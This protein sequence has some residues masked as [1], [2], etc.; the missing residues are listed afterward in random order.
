MKKVGLLMYRVFIGI[1]LF[2]IAVNA[3]E[4][5][6]TAVIKFQATDT[7]HFSFAKIF[8]EGVRKALSED[9]T[10][11]VLE[12]SIVDEMLNGSSA[13]DYQN[14]KNENCLM[15]IGKIISTRI[16][17]GGEIIFSG[18]KN[19]NVNMFLVD[20]ERGRT[21]F[22]L[23]KKFVYIQS[24]EQLYASECVKELTGKGENHQNTAL[25]KEKRPLLSRFSFWGP[26]TV[27]VAAIA[28]GAVLLNKSD[29][30]KPTSVDE[31]NIDDAPSRKR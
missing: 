17:V 10:H 12:E 29:S 7:T 30:E 20:T 27:I 22:S 26:S 11:Y 19:L 1:L 24:D 6:I 5:L 14:C 13:K 4:P 8:T 3:D 18:K 28:A 31:V 25:V 16:V 23:K 21:I 15:S 2:I 9:G